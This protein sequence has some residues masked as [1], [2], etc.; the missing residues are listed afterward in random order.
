MTTEKLIYL[1]Q[2]VGSVRGMVSYG[3]RLLISPPW[4]NYYQTGLAYAQAE[5]DAIQFQ[6]AY[7]QSVAQ[8]LE[9]SIKLVLTHIYN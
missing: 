5:L 6:M 3:E 2:L 1:T 4:H 8:S 7:Q 9:E